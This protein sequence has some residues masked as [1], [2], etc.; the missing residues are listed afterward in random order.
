[1]SLI[2]QL[3][4]LEIN[5]EKRRKEVLTNIIKMLTNR[6]LLNINKLEENINTITS[7]NVDTEVYKIKLD[8]PEIYYKKEVGEYFFVKIIDQRIT[9]ITKSTPIGEFLYDKKS[10][11]KLVIVPE[12]SNKILSQ[13]QY[14]FPNTEL[15]SE[16]ELM[17]DLVSHVSV[18]K[19]ELL[20]DEQVKDVLSDYLLRK[21]EIPKMFVTDPVS[22]Y[23][24]AKEGNVFRIVRYSELSG[25]SIYYRLVI[26]GDI[27]DV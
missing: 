13:I 23:F 2:P 21:R 18:P 3:L 17:M 11:P 4:P 1:M 26:S 9:G 15:F 6:K 20:N 25:Y 19:H 8:F 16:R 5:S 7:K 12:V 14:S 27:N 22:R 10:A 24:N